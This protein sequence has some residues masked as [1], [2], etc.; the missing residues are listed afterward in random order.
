MNSI[1]LMLLL[2]GG[3]APSAQ[4]P[5]RAAQGSAAEEYVVGPQD[6]ITLVVFNDDALSRPALSVDSEGTID[7][8][9]I[10]RVK[11]SGL[12]TRQIEEDLRKRLGLKRDAEGRVIGG[13]LNNP[14]ISVAVK[15]FRS[16]RVYVTGAVK[17]PGFV[18]LQGDPTL[19]RALAEAGYPTPESGSYVLITHAI[20]TH[21]VA[22]GTPAAPDEQV[23][24]GRDEI[25]TGRASRI[26]LRA[27]DF[28][29]VPTADK[30]FVTGEVKSMGQYVL[31]GELNVLQALAMAG[32]VTDRAN[33]G[34][35]KIE[36]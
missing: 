18:E 30:F 14:N 9:L 25:D 17:Q 5:P 12:T 21:P 34:K 36:R 35:I 23:K 32:G 1:L 3:Q 11:V 31:N 10:G 29:F 16:Q 4:E 26:R 15:D 6:V 19:T 33:K 13:Y 7:C 20:A 22:P 27:G 8:P 28:V 2:A 24:V